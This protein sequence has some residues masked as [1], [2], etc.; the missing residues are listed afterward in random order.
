M[1]RSPPRWGWRRRRTGVACLR[2][3]CHGC[4][5]ATSRCGDCHTLRVQAGGE[6]PTGGE[7]PH[8]TAWSGGRLSSDAILLNADCRHCGGVDH[9]RAES[10][11]KRN[12]K[13]ALKRRLRLR[14][15]PPLA[16]ALSTSCVSWPRLGGMRK[17]DCMRVTHPPRH[18]PCLS[19]SPLRCAPP[20][21]SRL[22]LW[23]RAAHGAPSPHVLHS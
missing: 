23:P 4:P 10:L 17:H 11:R 14:T 3:L 18:R 22:S 6:G 12:K 7:R 13:V 21:S 5:R 15:V 8:T 19:Q 9:G 16:L 2:C 1:A 20:C